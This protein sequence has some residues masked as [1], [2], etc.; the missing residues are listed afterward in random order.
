MTTY[1]FYNYWRTFKKVETEFHL[2]SM[3]QHKSRS[4]Y[5]LSLIILNFEFTLYNS[6][7]F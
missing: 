5:I 3:S 2:F 1:H 4:V 7:E 6:K